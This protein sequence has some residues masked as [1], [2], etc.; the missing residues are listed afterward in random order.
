M[1]PSCTWSSRVGPWVIPHTSDADIQCWMFRDASDDIHVSHIHILFYCDSVLLWDR[2]S[3]SPRPKIQQTLILGRGNRGK[4]NQRKTFKT[5]NCGSK[6]CYKFLILMC[7]TILGER[8][9]WWSVC[10]ERVQ[11]QDEG[12]TMIPPP[13]LP[14]SLP[15]PPPYNALCEIRN[16]SNTKW[17]L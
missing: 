2:W 1:F 4:P 17:I 10:G 9:G 13:S 14:P 12:G 15:P 8:K 11:M 6:I 3:I 7:T 5:S 16:S